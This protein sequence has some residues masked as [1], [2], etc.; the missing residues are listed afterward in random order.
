[1]ALTTRMTVYT[2]VDEYPCI[3]G[4]LESYHPELQR[5]VARD[6]LVTRGRVT[7]LAQV[8]P[9]CMVAP[10]KLV[11]DIQTEIERQTG[12]RP[13]IAADG[14]AIA[15]DR[16]LLAALRAIVDDLYAGATLSE[17]APRLEALTASVDPEA[18]SAMER[19]IQTELVG[20]ADARML[21]AAHVQV[22]SEAYEAQLTGAAN[23]HPLESLRAGSRRVS[24]AARRF[25]QVLTALGRPPA[26]SRWETRAGAGRAAFECLAEAE[27]H[28]DRVATILLPALERRG[29]PAASTLLLP[30]YQ[31]VRALLRRVRLALDRDDVGVVADAGAQLVAECAALAALEDKVVLPLARACLSNEDWADAGPDESMR[32]TLRADP[33]PSSSATEAP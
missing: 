21:D 20:D 1:M 7:T 15:A 8:A 13:A 4:F 31:A 14:E 32:S 19:A 26:R 6:A 3:E 10:A 30:R 12:A 23:G 16:A 28:F 5:V 9:R 33:S 29:R 18:V 11:R 22:I 27:Q 25:G 17:L 2:L 24:A